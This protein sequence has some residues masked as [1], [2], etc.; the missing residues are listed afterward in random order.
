[1]DG[2]PKPQTEPQTINPSLN[3]RPVQNG[4]VPSRSIRSPKLWVKFCTIKPSVT[5]KGIYIYIFT[6]NSVESNSWI[7]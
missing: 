1:M 4:N 2:N 6:T 3:L 5:N 7:A